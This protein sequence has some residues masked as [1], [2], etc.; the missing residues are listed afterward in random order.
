L[1]L[2]ARPPIPAGRPPTSAG[3]QRTAVRQGAAFHRRLS[4]SRLR[5]GR[6]SSSL[7]MQSGTTFKLA[8][9][10]CGGEQRP[11]DRINRID[12]PAYCGGQAWAMQRIAQHPA[13]SCNPVKTLFLFFLQP[14]AL[15][16][17]GVPAH[18]GACPRRARGLRRDRSATMRN[19]VALGA[20]RQR[21]SGANSM[22]CASSARTACA[23]PAFTSVACAHRAQTL[24]TLSI[25]APCPLARYKVR[26]LLAGQQHDPP[27][28]VER[29]ISFSGLRPF[30]RT[31]STDAEPVRPKARSF[32]SRNSRYS[33]PFRQGRNGL[34]VPDFRSGLRENGDWHQRSEARRACT[35]FRKAL[36]FPSVAPFFRGCPYSSGPACCAR[37]RDRQ[38]RRPFRLF[39]SPLIRGPFSLRHPLIEQTPCRKWVRTAEFRGGGNPCGIQEL[40]GHNRPILPA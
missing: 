29:P 9:P 30:S 27:G 20:D 17:R 28:E 32:N 35:R 6:A 5:A 15:W 18:G 4:R 33:H 39:L 11:F 21:A 34:P 23:V 7:P 22:C 26:P 25:R 1:Q 8:R 37:L 40:Q 16:A 19:T 31:S 38:A 3:N 14:S 10:Q 2:S 24:S 12:R 36:C 13:L